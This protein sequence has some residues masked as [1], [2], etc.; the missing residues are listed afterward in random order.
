MSSI[1]S[2]LEEA[3]YKLD[4]HI[5]TEHPDADLTE[6]C[7]Y[8]DDLIDQALKD[9]SELIDG[10]IPYKLDKEDFGQTWWNHA[11]AEYK[12]NLKELLK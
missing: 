2:I 9:I 3:F 5:M 6:K 10:A 4:K 8:G 1:R 7:R 12:R 11:I